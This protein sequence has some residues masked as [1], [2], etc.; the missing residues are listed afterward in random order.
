MRTSRIAKD[1]QHVATALTS[2]RASA[3]RSL[4]SYV[5]TTQEDGDGDG[6]NHESSVSDRG[7]SSSLGN[8]NESETPHLAKRKRDEAETP[9]TTSSA[10]RTTVTR[11]SPRKAPKLDLDREDASTEGTKRK[12]GRRPAK[13]IKGPN[14]AHSVEAPENWERI[15]AITAEMRKR[16]LAPVDTM[17]CETLAEDHR[18]PRDRRLQT[19]VALMLSSQTKDTVTA[20]AMKN[21]QV[22]LPGECFCLE[23]LLEVE[24]TELN[25]LIEKV[26]FH[27]NKT[28]FIKATAI[29]LRDNFG[30]DIPDT[31]GGLV[32]LPGV[33]P[34]MAYLCM[35][36][37]WGRDEGIGVDVH[38]HRI[39]NLWGWH[40]TSTPE[41]TR[42][43]LEAWL[44]KE[45]WHGINHLL[46]GFGQTICLPVGRRC[47]ECDLAK[48]KLCPSEVAGSPAKRRVKR[49][50]AIKSETEGREIE[51][52]KVKKEED[53]VGLKL[54]AVSKD[55]GQVELLQATAGAGV[56]S[57][58]PVT[59][60]QPVAG[61]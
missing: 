52:V 55:E 58:P 61:E 50:T 35:S 25:R 17:G 6:V 60:I 15:Y 2:I 59:T 31:I 13:H 45:K 10:Q 46:V 30:G 40:K 1:T 32:S 48:A 23:S 51:S 11:R 14:G 27:N 42:A 54:E 9:V 43:E 3:R 5:H 8:L 33:G 29:I 18:S 4:R 56:S 37:A 28:K 24:P 57:P 16:V 26:G 41:Q 19:L 34:K 53:D 36:A 44:P 20:A 21:L 12:P 47:G 38:V 49:E 39:T 22:N 7:Q